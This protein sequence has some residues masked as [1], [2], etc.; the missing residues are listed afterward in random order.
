[1]KR[2][3]GTSEQLVS[4]QPR[5]GRTHDN[6]TVKKACKAS[7]RGIFEIWH[8]HASHSTFFLGL[9]S[10]AKLLFFYILFMSLDWD[11][12]SSRCVNDC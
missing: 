11:T 5:G 7:V 10:Q 12:L 4:Q 1:M 2:V 9:A 6:A 8:K 3:R